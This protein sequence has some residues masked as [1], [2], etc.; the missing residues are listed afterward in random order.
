MDS[1]ILGVDIS[2]RKFDVALLDGENIKSKVYSNDLDGFK[3]LVEW[4]GN[5][6]VKPHVCLE[7]TS[8]YGHGLANYLYSFG[9]YVSMVNPARIK[10]FSHCELSRTKT[11]KADAKMIARFC[12]AMRPSKWTPEEKWQVELKQWNAHADKLKSILRMELNRDAGVCKDVS[13]AIQR[14]VKFIEKQIKATGVKIN[15]LIESH[16][17]LK[18]KRILL[19]SI[20]GIGKTTTAHLLAFMGDLKRFNSAK[21]ITAY[22]GLNPQHK[23]SGSSVRGRTR[24]SKTGHSGLRKALYMPALVAIRYNPVMREFYQKLVA[25]GKAKKAAIFAVMRK[26]L[27]VSYAILKNK[28]PYQTQKKMEPITA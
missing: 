3:K 18:E 13:K 22:A 17:E 12:A 11:D 27:V 20:P 21:Q 25:R 26:L 14:H 2:K 1:T 10:G 7:A 19:E 5:R 15:E 6:G 4:L 28:T 24:I 16:P 23:Q 9:Y 8:F